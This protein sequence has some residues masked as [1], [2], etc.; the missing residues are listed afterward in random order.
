MSLYIADP[1]N[2]KAQDALGDGAPELMN[3]GG[4]LA[5]AGW[6]ILMSGAAFWAWW[7][8]GDPWLVWMFAIVAAVA[9]LICIAGAEPLTRRKM[10]KFRACLKQG[11]II[12]VPTAV[13]EAFVRAADAV[14]VNPGSRGEIL[15]RYFWS[16]RSVVEF[17]QNLDDP[18]ISEEN[19]AGI[20]GYIDD[21]MA[22]IA[23]DLLREQYERNY[24]AE[25]NAALRNGVLETRLEHERD[26]WQ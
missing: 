13:L 12:E 21:R 8:D 18:T 25:S 24:V 19:K 14:H 23:S 7:H 10:R 16:V 9:A 3:I 2:R 15:G 17:A 4:P 6:C 20:R 1:N 22:E 5:P 11:T 26:G